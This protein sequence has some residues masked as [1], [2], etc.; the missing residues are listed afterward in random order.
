MA[1]H[2]GHPNYVERAAHTGPPTPDD[3]AAT[4]RAAVAGEEGHAH[5]GGN[6][7]AVEPAQFGHLGEQGQG[8]GGADA[9]H[10]TQQVLPR[11]PQQAVLDRVA[12][13]P[14]EVGQLLLQPGDMGRDAG[15]HRR[16]CRVEP[17]ALG[18]EHGHDLAAPAQQ[19]AQLLR[20]GIG[21]RLRGWPDHL[22]EAGEHLCIQVVGLGQLSDAACEVAHLARVDDSSGHPGTRQ[23][24]D[25]RHL[26]PPGRFE[27]HQRRGQGLQARDQRAQPHLRGTARAAGG[28]AGR[29]RCAQRG[30]GGHSDGMRYRLDGGLNGCVLAHLA[31]VTSTD[32]AQSSKLHAPLATVFTSL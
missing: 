1:E 25:E 9:G 26:A 5:Q 16:Q 31:T 28:A 17:L 12:Q 22:G 11:P 6:G 23:G 8:G 3:A 13:V 27:H 29:P 18:S 21:H 4:Q 10:T 2:R 20:P 15:L 14:V 7:L 24:R 30:A 19:G 32:A